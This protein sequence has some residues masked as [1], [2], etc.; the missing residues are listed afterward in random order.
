TASTAMPAG[1]FFDASEMA[2]LDLLTETI[3]PADG[4]SGGAHAA[5]VA[6]YIDGRL[7]ES[8][9]AIPALR[10]TREH[11]KAGLAALD[12]LARGA[13]GKAFLE[14][15]AEERLEILERL[16]VGEGELHEGGSEEEGWPESADLEAV[17]RRFFVLLKTWT[18]FGYYTSS[19]G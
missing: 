6:S 14:A 9:P 13:T 15:T 2:L 12:G 7:A 1:R 11:G 18:A 3:I 10:V 17:G 19:V 8:D 16:A 5:G 4:Y